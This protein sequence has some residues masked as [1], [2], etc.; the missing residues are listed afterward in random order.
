M[1]S[2]ALY[3]LETTLMNTVG[4]DMPDLIFVEFTSNDWNIEI[5]GK[6]ELCIQIESLFREIRC[7]NPVAEIVTVITPARKQPF[8][9][10]LY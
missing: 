7:I 9:Q 3:R 2:L 6:E 5:Q 1:T 8:A 10:R 4:H